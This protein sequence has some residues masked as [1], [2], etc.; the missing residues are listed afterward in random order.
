[1]SER[2]PMTIHQQA[3]FVD[4]LVQRASRAPD[5]ARVQQAWLFLTDDEIADLEALGQRLH[6]MAPHEGDIRDLVTGR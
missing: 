6:R 4:Y 3:E 1:M 5:G 2:Q